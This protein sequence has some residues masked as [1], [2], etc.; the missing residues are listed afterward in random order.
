VLLNNL[1]N[2]QIS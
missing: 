1:L 2:L